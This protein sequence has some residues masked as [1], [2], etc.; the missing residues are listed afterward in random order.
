MSYK[1]NGP[2]N[3]TIKVTVSTWKGREKWKRGD[4][5]IH[6]ALPS[7]S[8]RTKCMGWAGV[9]AV[10]GVGTPELELCIW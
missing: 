2:G 6:R 9:F 10:S 3:G 1:K 5:L 8:L 7:A 4:T